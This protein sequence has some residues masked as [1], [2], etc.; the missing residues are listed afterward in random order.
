MIQ[1]IKSTLLNITNIRRVYLLNVDLNVF[2]EIILVQVHN[3]IV[4]E[5][6]PEMKV[7]STTHKSKLNP[8][9]FSKILITITKS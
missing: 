5:V 8:T 4:H 7:L 9:I 2:L 1:M 3:K 6:E